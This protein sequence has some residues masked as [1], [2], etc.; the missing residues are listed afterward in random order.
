MPK[1]T[2]F[3]SVLDLCVSGSRTRLHT[4]LL[5]PMPWRLRGR[6]SSSLTGGMVM[7]T[8]ALTSNMPS[9][10]KKLFY[11]KIAIHKVK[12]VVVLSNVFVVCKIVQ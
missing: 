11:K 8:L 6:R 2:L 3:R 4:C 12:V 5:Q 10:N 1:L 9:N 7:Y